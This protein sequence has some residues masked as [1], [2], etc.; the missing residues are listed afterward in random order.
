MKKD[1]INDD[2]FYENL[3]AFKLSEYS[4]KEFRNNILVTF[5]SFIEFGLI[6]DDLEL[7]RLALKAKRLLADNLSVH[8][9][10]TNKQWGIVTVYQ[11]GYQ[12]ADFANSEGEAFCILWFCK[13]LFEKY[14]DLLSF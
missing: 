13:K 7:P 9:N 5:N 1:I 3:V 6:K 2:T 12:V 10:T 4:K 8:S 14:P 11:N